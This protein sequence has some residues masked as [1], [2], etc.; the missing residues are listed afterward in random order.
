MVLRYTR[1]VTVPEIGVK[2]HKKLGSSSVLIVGCGGLGSHVIPILAACGLKRLVLCDDDVVKASN[3]NRQT[4]YRERDIGRKKVMAAAEFVRECN[5]DV[6]VHTIDRAVG[7]RNFEDVLSN[8]EVVVDCVD[9]LIVKMVLNDACVVMGKA[10]I[11]CAAIGFVGEVMTVLPGGRPCYRCFFEADRADSK[12]NCA[13][14]GVLGSTVGVIGSMAASEVIK[15]IA[16]VPSCR[17]GRLHRVNLLHNRFST[18]EFTANEQCKC[19][20]MHGDI[21]PQAPES[22]EGRIRP[23][24]RRRPSADIS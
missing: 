11:H 17:G 12:L 3:L 1:Q 9:R 5:S 18:Y 2:G 22:Y 14:A 21:E 23:H 7:P 8:I 19:C 20:S 10:L 6:E 16:G 15:Y 13:S 24:S 4:I